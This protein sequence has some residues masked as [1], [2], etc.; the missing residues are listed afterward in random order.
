MDGREAVRLQPRV[1]RIIFYHPDGTKYLLYDEI[2]G[3]NYNFS[4]IPFSDVCGE[5]WCADLDQALIDGTIT[6]FSYGIL[7]LPGDGYLA[8]DWYFFTP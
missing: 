2:P 7:T 8:V 6:E 5:T 3:G 1:R 4:Y